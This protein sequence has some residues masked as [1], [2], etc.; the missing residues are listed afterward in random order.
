MHVRI[1]LKSRDPELSFSG[2]THSFLHIVIQKSD[3][4]QTD[5]LWTLKVIEGHQN[6]CH[7]K[8]V[9]RCPING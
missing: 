2:S 1:S 5:V 8:A 7:M 6:C 9:I 3:I 4:G